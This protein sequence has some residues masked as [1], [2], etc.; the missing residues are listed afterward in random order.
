MNRR[1]FTSLIRFAG[2]LLAACALGGVPLA[3]AHSCSNTTGAGTWA[4]TVTGTVVLP[5]GVVVPVAQVGSF[6]QDSSGDLI[7]SQT[8]SLGGGVAQETFTG[9]TS[10]NPDCTGQVTVYVYDKQSGA[11][12]RTSTLDFILVDDGK[13]AR[14]IVTSI[15]LPN[16]ASLGPVLTVEYK[17][18]EATKRK[19]Q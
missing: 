2:T 16:G 9:T 14:A 4:F 5:T 12:V 3:H 15:V 19:P 8:R 6:K 18:V 7:G 11:L 10:T 1:T 17:R 13:E